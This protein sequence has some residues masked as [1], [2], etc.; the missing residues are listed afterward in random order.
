MNFVWQRKSVGAVYPEII[1]G[2]ET[3]RLISGRG[4]VKF[5]KLAD[6]TIKKTNL[7]KIID[8]K[9]LMDSIKPAPPASPNTASPPAQNNSSDSNSQTPPATN[10]PSTPSTPADT[11]GGGG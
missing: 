11:T 9:Q 7:G 10:Q 4:F 3:G 6:G 1:N 5:E 2:K 8:P